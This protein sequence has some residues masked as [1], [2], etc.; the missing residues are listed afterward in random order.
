MKITIIRLWLEKQF[1]QVYNGWHW[2]SSCM[3]VYWYPWTAGYQ[4]FLPGIITYIHFGLPI[5]LCFL[6]HLLFYFRGYSCFLFH[7]LFI[8]RQYNAVFIFFIYKT[9]WSCQHFFN[10]F[11]LINS[12]FFLPFSYSFFIS[13]VALYTMLLIRYLL[14][15]G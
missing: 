15:K 8:V 14:S 12:N 7:L 2:E 6:H 5:Y 10:Y 13:T 9:L 3:T 1:V 11:L 4:V